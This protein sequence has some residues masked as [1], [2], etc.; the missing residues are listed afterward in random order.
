VCLQ[1]MVAHLDFISAF[2]L[3]CTSRFY[4]SEILTLWTREHGEPVSLTDVG[5]DHAY[6]ERFVESTITKL[7][8]C[9]IFTSS[10]CLELISAV[11]KQLHMRH[12]VAALDIAFLLPY[13]APIPKSSPQDAALQ[14]AGCSVAENLPS[15]MHQGSDSKTPQAKLTPF[16]IA[17]ACR[18]AR[19]ENA[20]LHEPFIRRDENLV[21]NPNGRM[22]SLHLDITRLPNAHLGVRPYRHVTVRRAALSRHERLYA[23][24][25]TAACV[26]TELLL[27]FATLIHEPKICE[28]LCELSAMQV[29]ARCV[30]ELS[31]PRATS[32]T[33]S[34]TRIG[35]EYNAQIGPHVDNAGARTASCAQ[36]DSKIQCDAGSQATAAGTTSSQSIESPGADCITVCE[37]LADCPYVLDVRRILKTLVR[38]RGAGGAWLHVANLAADLGDLELLDLVAQTCNF[39]PLEAADIKSRLI[40]RTMYDSIKIRR[41]S[42]RRKRLATFKLPVV[43]HPCLQQRAFSAHSCCSQTI[44]PE[45]VVTRLLPYA[46]MI[47]ENR[48]NA[49]A[50]LSC[51]ETP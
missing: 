18:S 45:E 19:V 25:D 3:G 32:C 39:P 43:Y 17:I 35:A 44:T 5:A 41:I 7:D 2:L 50:W 26:N 28:L 49:I 6:S 4:R 13:V 29:P 30:L 23:R 20:M 1:R 51:H 31:F 9:P 15:N 46:A 34:Y 16:Q 22:S 27:E 33:E 10:S 38:T 24:M 14:T 37:Y 42:E 8:L 48:S 12:A 11:P 21:D 40:W 36:V 47:Q